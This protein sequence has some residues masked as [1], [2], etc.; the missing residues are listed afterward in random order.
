MKNKK[1]NKVGFK[2]VY[3]NSNKVKPIVVYKDSLLSKFKALDDNIGKSAVY[4]WVHRNNKS[5]VGSSKDLYR[6]LKYYYY[7]VD[8]LEKIVIKSDSRIYKALLEDGYA[9]FNLEILEYCDKNKLFEREQYYIDL[10]KTEYNIQNIAGIVLSPRGS[11]TTVIN[12][13]DG[14]IKVYVSIYAA[15]KAIN[16]KYSTIKYYVNKD[17]LLKGTYLITSKPKVNKRKGCHR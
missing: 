4:R 3:I 17:K 10:I 2:K 14:S 16:I 12:E 11:P 1:Y 5:Y 15:A 13:K 6:R 8:F 9:S 7:N